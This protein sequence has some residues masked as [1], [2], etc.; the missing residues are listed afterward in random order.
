MFE[1]LKKEHEQKEQAHQ[2]EKTMKVLIHPE[3][4]K[5]GQ[6]VKQDPSIIE[7]RDRVREIIFASELSIL[8]KNILMTG[9]DA[10]LCAYMD[11]QESMEGYMYYGLRKKMK[12]EFGL[13]DAC[14]DWCVD[15]WS[16][17]Y[18]GIVRGIPIEDYIYTEDFRSRMRHKLDNRL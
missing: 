9:Y 14:A 7:S 1:S 15:M 3:C 4:R 5:I 12:T 18:A 16:K 6:A 13:T 17:L 8:R 11:Q 2:K 10:G